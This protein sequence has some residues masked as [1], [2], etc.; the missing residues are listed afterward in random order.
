M[1]T[2]AV[3]PGTF[4]PFTAGHL[5]VVERVRRHFA[6]VT[7]LV[8]VNPDKQPA[9]DPM[10]RAEAVRRRLPLNWDNVAVAAWPGLTAAFCRE[11][12]ARVIVRGIRNQ[13]DVR[14]EHQLAAMNEAL[15]IT[16][17]LVPARPELATVSSTSVRALQR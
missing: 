2:H 12:H 11:N 6:L 10:E 15:G 8:A 13:A 5:D 3:Y 17:L 14:L 16:T 9:V 4:H 7:V 1:G